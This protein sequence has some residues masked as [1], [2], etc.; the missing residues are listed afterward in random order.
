MNEFAPSYKTVGVFTPDNLIA[1]AFPQVRKTIRLSGKSGVLKRG[2]VIG[3]NEN[4]YGPLSQESVP[5]GIL[6]ETVDTSET[7]AVVVYLTGE[8]SGDFMHFFDAEPA[9]TIESLRTLSIFV[10]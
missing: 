4:I 6:A 1:G 10:H 3:K 8:F 7:L 2:S 5:Y 9:K